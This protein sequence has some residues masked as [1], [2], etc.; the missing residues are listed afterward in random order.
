MLELRAVSKTFN[1]GTPNELRAGR[2]L[3]GNGEQGIARENGDA[4]AENFVTRRAATA[5]IVVIHARQII[6]NER[7]GVD[8]FHGAGVRQRRRR[9][10]SAGFGS[11]ETKNGPEPFPAGKQTVAHRLVQRDRRHGR[12]RQ[13]PIERAVDLFLPAGKV[14][15][16][17]RLAHM[18]IRADDPAFQD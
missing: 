3:E 1:P 10:T 8:A 14:A 18:V 17:M 9:F 6:V 4:V 5:E 15:L 7:V 16:Q 13:E 11:G 2:D 12:L